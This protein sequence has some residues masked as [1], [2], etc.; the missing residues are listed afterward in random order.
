MGATVERRPP[1]GQVRENRSGSSRRGEQDLTLAERVQGREVGGRKRARSSP[2]VQGDRCTGS[3]GRGTRAWIEEHVEGSEVRCR[4]CTHA[5]IKQAEVSGSGLKRL[6]AL[7]YLQPDPTL[8]A[9]VR[10]TVGRPEPLTADALARDLSQLSL[11]ALVPEEITDMYLVAVG[12][13]FYGAFYYPL[14]QLGQQQLLRVCDAA[15]KTRCVQLGS[16]KKTFEKAIDALADVGIIR[17]PDV[18]RWHAIRSSRNLSSHADFAHI[19][20]PGDALGSARRRGAMI[21]SL[22]ASSPE[23]L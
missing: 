6:D 10:V 15:A 20:A 17:G 7:N 9:F 19:G 1:N 12:A 4:E 11:S 22:F 5:A 8:D 2:H 21:D 13:M 23:P 16:P 3:I 18:G 14:F